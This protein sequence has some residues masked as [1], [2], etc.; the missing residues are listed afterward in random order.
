MYAVITIEFEFPVKKD[1][2]KFRNDVNKLFSGSCFEKEYQI[3]I[4]PV[5][6]HLDDSRDVWRFKIMFC[7]DKNDIDVVEKYVKISGGTLDLMNGSRQ[8]WAFA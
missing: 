1:A 3:V 8:V 7:K 6:K 4:S 2:Y 5:I